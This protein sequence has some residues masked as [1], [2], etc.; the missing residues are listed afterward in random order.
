MAKAIQ[1]CQD[2]VTDRLAH[3]GYS[4]VSFERT[5][6]DDQPGRHDWVVGTA[7]A[8]RQWRLT[9]F[10]FSCSVNFSSGTVRSVDVRRR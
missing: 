4:R 5:I 3:D 1:I 7:S 10:S 2:S 6:P 9:W 8:A